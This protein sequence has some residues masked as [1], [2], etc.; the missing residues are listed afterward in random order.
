MPAPITVTVDAKGMPQAPIDPNVPLPPSVARAA[1]RADELHKAAYAPQP[2]PQA[3][4]PQPAHR[5]CQLP[6]R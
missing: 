4:A 1:A 3:P 6:L 2:D 5:W